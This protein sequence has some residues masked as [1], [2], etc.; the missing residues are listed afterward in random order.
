MNN[1]IHLKETRAVRRKTNHEIASEKLLLDTQRK[2]R[3]WC[4]DKIQNYDI[5][6]YPKV[7]AKQRSL[8]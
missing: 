1:P 3:P 8:C 4:K 5:V 6:H 7:V 2:Q